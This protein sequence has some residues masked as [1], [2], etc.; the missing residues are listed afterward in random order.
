M[1]KAYAAFKPGGE[2]RPF[3]Y[4]PGPILLILDKFPSPKGIVRSAQDLTDQRV[5]AAACVTGQP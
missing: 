1:I 4:N 2:L 5:P 3:E